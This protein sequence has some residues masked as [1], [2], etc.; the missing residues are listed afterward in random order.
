MKK[1][2]TVLNIIIG[3]FIGAFVGYIIYTVW[4]YKT[5]PMLY[6]MQPRSWYLEILVR[7][8]VTIFVIFFCMV[9]KAVIKR[10]AI[11][12]CAAGVFLIL[13]ISVTLAVYGVKH[14]GGNVDNVY[15]ADWEPSEI[16]SDEDIEGACQTVIEYF[17]MEFGGCTLTELY[18]AEDSYADEF[19]DLAESMNVDEAIILK[20]LRLM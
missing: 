17:S 11:S 5:N 4:Y 3:S 12:I 2:N 8:L 1:W 19:E 15:I 6:V 14:G 9:I 10:N 7:G 20:N 16:Y 18:Y 13:L